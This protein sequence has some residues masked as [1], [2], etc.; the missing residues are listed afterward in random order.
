MAERAI[1][2][3]AVARET[4]AREHRIAEALQ[5]SLLP[6]VT[7]ESDY[8]EVATYYQAGVEGT[9][10]GGDW[11]DAIDLGGGRV[12]LIVGDVVGRGIAAAS[13]MGQLRAAA[14]AYAQLDL[15][16]SEV[17]ELLDGM[18]R[19]L[20]QDQLV[21]CIYGIYDPAE[22]E[23][24][25]ANAGHLPPL[26]VHAG[27]PPERLPAAGGPPLGAGPW[28]IDEHRLV[29]PVGTMI[30]LYTDGLV[31]RRDRDLD[32]GISKLAGQLVSNGQSIAELADRVVGSLAPD[33]SE[34]D[35]AILLARVCAESAPH[36]AVLEVPPEPSA[37][38]TARAFTDSTLRGWSLAGEVVDDAALIL[39]E[40]LTNAIVHGAPPIRIR[41]RRTRGELAIEVDDGA[42]AMPR[43][44]RTTPEDEHGRGLSIVAHLGSR[45]AARPC[46][47]GKTVWSTL[48]LETAA[49]RG[50][51]D[52]ES[53]GSRR[54]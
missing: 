52:H 48:P 41:L 28:E 50:P 7:V 25:Y 19:E 12:A 4:A 11:Y 15:P 2:T 46:G 8:L 29:L 33:G 31:E 39:S 36:T 42:S 51:G 34:D 30:A 13:V 9:S 20:G 54:V 47:H 16:P 35:I 5:R 45:W 37:L 27:K 49:E 32:A 23:F 44:L 3:A 38:R 24:R 1:A 6:P 40:L 53:I 18:V 43:K 22:S 21:T 10:V 26:L 14:R 17:L